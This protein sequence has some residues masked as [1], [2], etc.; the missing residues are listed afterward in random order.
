MDANGY[1]T[2]EEQRGILHAVMSHPPSNVLDRGLLEALDELVDTLERDQASVLVLSSAQPE[3]FAVGPDFG[4]NEPLTAE[5]MAAYKEALRRPLERLAGCGRLSIAAIDGRAL[6]A[7]LELAMACTLR[8]CSRT[9]RFG[10][11]DLACGRIPV[12]GGTQRLPRLVG[13]GRALEL[14]L[15]GREVHG[16]EALRIGLVERLLYRDVAEE[17][18]EA[19]FRLAR[20]PASATGAIV[21]CVNAARDLPHESGLAVEGAAL[22]AAFEEPERAGT[23]ALRDGR[24]PAAA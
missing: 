2:V 24:R 18:C 8:F 16:D 19:A 12:G 21:T 14:L 20:S 23:R 6:G 9:A 4:R 13:R 15:T 1:L 11:P 17:A 7:G 5:Q 10:F 22:L 3:F